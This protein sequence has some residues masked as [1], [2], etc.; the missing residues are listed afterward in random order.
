MK[1]LLDRNILS[2]KLTENAQ[3]EYDLCITQDVLDESNFTKQ[4]ISRIKSQG[5]QTLNL[6]K[7]HFEKLK[8]V[9]ASHGTNTSLINLFTGQGAADVAMMA[10]ILA[11]QEADKTLFPEQ[12]SI[13]TK[14]T[15]LTKVAQSYG[16]NCVTGLD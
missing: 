7:R 14:D 9:M 8:E 15:E 4:D 2:N 16:I 1:Y 6:S 3:N 5:I 10:Y 13:V 11:E 12:Y